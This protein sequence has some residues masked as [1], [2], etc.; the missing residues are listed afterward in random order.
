MMLYSKKTH[1]Y[2]GI[3]HNSFLEAL[4]VALIGLAFGMLIGLGILT[5]YGGGI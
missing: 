3:R 5:T 1:K 2:Y 4:I